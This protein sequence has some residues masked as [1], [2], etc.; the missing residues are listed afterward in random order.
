LVYLA[1]RR[2]TIIDRHSTRVIQLRVIRPAANKNQIRMAQ[3]TKIESRL[4][5]RSRT[6][7]GQ[8][9]VA[10]TH[11]IHHTEYA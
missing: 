9:H 2:E 1:K 7:M 10:H 5:P 4:L 6:S 3:Q 8:C 11:V